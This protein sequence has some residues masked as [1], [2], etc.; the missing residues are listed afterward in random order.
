MLESDRDVDEIR[1]D[2]DDGPIAYQVG[3]EAE[4]CTA[5]IC[6]TLNEVRHFLVLPRDWICIAL[7]FDDLLPEIRELFLVFWQL[8]PIRC[9]ILDFLHFRQ[10]VE[11]VGIQS[12]LNGVFLL[13]YLSGLLLFVADLLCDSLKQRL[14]QCTL[15]R[16][17]GS[18]GSTSVHLVVERRHVSFEEAA[19]A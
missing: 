15:A 18:R 3:P 4:F 9:L 13:L 16:A 2:D 6:K 17:F 14:H 5:D 7:F 10:Q 1:Q 8:I 12:R 19:D 11:E